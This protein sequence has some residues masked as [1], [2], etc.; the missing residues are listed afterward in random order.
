M[1]VLLS[2][3]AGFVGQRL[4]RRLVDVRFEVAAL[5]LLHR[6]V[7][8][9][10][11]AARAAFPGTVVVGDV[12]DRRAWSDATAQVRRV[13]ALVHLAAETGTA[14]SMYEANRYH[15]VNVDGT[16]RAA[17][18][19]ACAWRCRRSRAATSKRRSTSRSA[20][21]WPRKPAPPLSSTV[22][23]APEA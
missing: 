22:T 16:R 6:Q 21:R 2:G 4:A 19:S 1:T 13:E 11:E 17:S 23:R 18:G 14:Q 10:P 5:D 9:D 8:A 12:A 3:G 15:R 20:S 7:H